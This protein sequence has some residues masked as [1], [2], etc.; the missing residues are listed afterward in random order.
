VTADT[1][2]DHHMFSLLKWNPQAIKTAATLMKCDK[3]MNLVNLYQL[4]AQYHGDP[5]KAQVHEVLKW[6]QSSYHFLKLCYYLPGSFTR[7][8]I[9]AYWEEWSF[10]KKSS[11]PILENL[12][13]KDM[14]DQKG[15]AIS[16]NR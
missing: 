4:I 2:G 16:L 7:D 11:G 5:R 3:N 15:Q 9:S 10:V 6:D 12:L 8:D 14:L 13:K 1:I